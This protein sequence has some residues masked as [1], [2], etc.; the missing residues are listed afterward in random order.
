MCSDNHLPNRS[1]VDQ[2]TEYIF[3][4]KNNVKKIDVLYRA[5]TGNGGDEGK[6]TVGY[7]VV[8]DGYQVKGIDFP[9]AI[10]DIRTHLCRHN[11][12]LIG[13]YKIVFFM[14]CVRI[15]WPLQPG[16]FKPVDNIQR[17][18]SPDPVEG[19]IARYR[20]GRFPIEPNGIS[21][22]D[23]QFV[24]MFHNATKPVGYVL[25]N[26]PIHSD[27]LDNVIPF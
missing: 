5:S 26:Y 22:E 3:P 9:I 24:R 19:V 4:V 21:R 7:S 16:T 20:G 8:N 23:M 10:L 14:Q 18:T 11:S 12:R 2:V 27:A 17:F 6:P 15:L 13:S 1:Y 25:T